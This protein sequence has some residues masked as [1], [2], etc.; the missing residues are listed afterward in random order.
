MM[1]ITGTNAIFQLRMTRIRRI[2]RGKTESD[3]SSM[4][5]SMSLKVQSTIKFLED[6]L[7]QISMSSLVDFSLTT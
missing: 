4:E 3:S 7:S 1:L 2:A 6:N 5:V